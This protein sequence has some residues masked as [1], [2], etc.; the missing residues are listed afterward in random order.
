MLG[1]SVAVTD[2]ESIFETIFNATMESQ[3][4]C[5]SRAFPPHPKSPA[6][7]KIA[8]TYLPTNHLIKV[9]KS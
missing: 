9:Y 1:Q 2:F 7:P 8:L 6:I 3:M 5:V 4:L